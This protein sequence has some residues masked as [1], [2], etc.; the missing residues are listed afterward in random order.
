[1]VCV[2]IHEILFQHIQLYHLENIAMFHSEGLVH[3]SWGQYQHKPQLLYALSQA[4]I[5]IMYIIGSTYR[6]ILIV[7]ENFTN[8]NFGRVTVYA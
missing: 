7:I 2:L 5:I 4:T 3:Q 1:M 6:V 8:T